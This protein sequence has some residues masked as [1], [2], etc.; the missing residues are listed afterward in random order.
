MW[1]ALG[2]RTTDVMARGAE[3]L[4]LFSESAW[5]EG[6]A[7]PSAAPLKKTDLTAIPEPQLMNLYNDHDGFLPARWLKEM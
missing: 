7:R 1:N 4:A 2:P 6:R 3:A 5:R